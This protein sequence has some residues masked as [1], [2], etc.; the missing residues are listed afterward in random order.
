[1]SLER[2]EKPRLPRTSIWLP[3]LI[4]ISTV[5]VHAIEEYTTNYT[6]TVDVR[7]R[8]NDVH[9]IWRAGVRHAGRGAGDHPLFNNN[10]LIPTLYALEKWKSE[11]GLARTTRIDL[12]FYDIDRAVDSIDMAS[13]ADWVEEI[14]DAGGTPIVVLNTIP[15]S[16]SSCPLTEDGCEGRPTYAPSDYAAWED[17]VYDAITYLSATGVTVS[18]PMLGLENEMSR[19]LGNLYYH[20]WTEPNTNSAALGGQPGPFLGATTYWKGNR[21]EFQ[22]LYAASVRA[23]ERAERDHGLALHV[24]GCD[25]QRVEPFLDQVIE[26]DPANWIVEFVRYCRD[27]GLRL[28]F[29]SWSRK[30]NDPRFEEKYPVSATW[31]RM[32]DDYG[33]DRTELILIDFSSQ[34]YVYSENG[35][36]NIIPVE[37]DSEILASLIPAVL[38]REDRNGLIDRVIL[39]SIQDYNPGGENHD[40][41]LFSGGNGQSFTLSTVIKPSFNT[42]RM[43]SF[44]KDKELEVGKLQSTPP[45]HQDPMLEAAKDI[46]CMATID[47]ETGD[48][49]VLVW[50][51]FNPDILRQRSEGDLLYEDL[52]SQLPSRQRVL[53]HIDGLSLMHRYDIHRYMLSKDTSNSWAVR[54]AI[55]DALNDKVPAEEIN[56]WP[57][58]ELQEVETR[59]AQAA[60][61][62]GFRLQM[63]PYSVQLIHLV[64]NDGGSNMPPSEAA[65]EAGGR[66]SLLTSQNYPNP[67]I[68]ETR[69]DFSLSARPEGAV[70]AEGTGGGGLSG[71][72]IDG[73]TVPVS[74]QIFDVRGRLVRTLLH[75]DVGFDTRYSI[76][77]DAR[78][79]RGERVTY[80]PYFYRVGTPNR[81]LVKKMIYTG[82][83]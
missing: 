6:F 58:V 55:H 40:Y 36:G 14:L 27:N 17:L 66:N 81:V 82:R 74:V 3:V 83:E 75:E 7:D 24:G 15:D 13:I 26:D 21:R 25:F 41:G 77:W 70:G 44:L 12:N 43:L 32:L 53:I 20:V 46:D 72:G 73:G 48:I 79:D 65:D 78:N 68:G 50:Y 31:R 2:R 28:D 62:M 42:F 49:A 69:I 56:S 35:L 23:V 22:E 39:E 47:S 1:M 71:D 10:A 59:P 57:E 38:K 37:R 5:A 63:T 8:R 51:Y 64:R 18:N 29:F 80:G 60:S 19:G 61:Q 34:I 76:V 16:I 33:Y 4:L 45:P 52:T 9:E 67:F 11:V 54:Q 30:S